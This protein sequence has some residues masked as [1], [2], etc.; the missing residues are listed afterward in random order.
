MKEQHVLHL[1]KAKKIQDI[2]KIEIEGAT[3]RLQLL[4]F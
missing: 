4:L 3:T 1:D 2:L